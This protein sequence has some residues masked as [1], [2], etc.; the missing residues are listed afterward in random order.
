LYRSSSTGGAAGVGAAGAA[1]ARGA[2]AKKAARDY[3]LAK[4]MPQTIPMTF[5]EWM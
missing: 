1:G 4:P 5:H 3:L 2:G